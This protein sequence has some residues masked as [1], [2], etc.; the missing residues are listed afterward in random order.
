M[1]RYV[2]LCIGLV[3]S[4]LGC[5]NDVP[6]ERAGSS[7]QASTVLIQAGEGG[8]LEPPPPPT[9]TIT[10]TFTQ[11]SPTSTAGSSVQFTWTGTPSFDSF[12]TLSLYDTTNNVEVDSRNE[13]G[14]E[15]GAATTITF[16]V[17][18]LG[19]GPHHLEARFSAF[20]LAGSPDVKSLDHLVQASTTTSIY[21]SLP[22]NPEGTTFVYGEPMRAQTMVYDGTPQIGG[23]YPSVPAN[24]TVTFTFGALTLGSCAVVS[25]S[26]DCEI[27]GVPAGSER[28]VLGSFVPS[29]GSYYLGSEGTSNLVTVTPAATTATITGATPEPSV[30]GGPV[31]FTI[32][33]H[34][35]APSTASPTGSVQFFRDGVG[36]PVGSAPLT[37]GP[38]GEST[39]TFTV[40]SGAIIGSVGS[41]SVHVTYV[42]DGPP[43]NFTGSTSSTYAHVVAQDT[44]NRALTVSTPSPWGFGTALTFTATVANQSAGSGAPTGTVYFYDGV[45]LTPT[46][47]LGSDVLHAIGPDQAARITISTLAIG[48]HTITALYGGDANHGVGTV[49]L[50]GSVVKST[51]TVEV[52][53][54]PGSVVYS[55]PVTFGATVH[56]TTTTPTGTVQFYVDGSTPIGSPVSL[57][58]G[59]ASLG[60]SSVAAGTDRPITA[61]YAGDSLYTTATGNGLLTVGLAPTSTALTTSSNPAVAGAPVTFSATV[62]RLGLATAVPVGTVTFTQDGTPLG[63]PQTLDGSG[64]A[65]VTVSTLP[66][67]AALAIKAQYNGTSNFGAS[68][69]TLDQEITADGVTTIVVASPSPSIVG[70]SVTFTATFGGSVASVA[71]GSAELF[72]GATSLGT[73]SLNASGA[74]TFSTST[75]AAGNHTITVKYGGDASHTKSSGTVAHAVNRLGSTTTLATTADVTTPFGVVVP[76]VATVTSSSGV[77]TGPVAFK[78]GDTVLGSVAL[79]ATGKATFNA[80]S[81][82]VGSHALTASFGGD[83]T[84][85]PSASETLSHTVDKATTTIL[86]SSSLNPAP[87]G[88]NVL[89]SA[90]IAGPATSGTPSGTVTFKDGV[91][92][93]GSGSVNASGV[94]QFATSSLGAG[95]HAITAVYAGDAHFEGS[96]SVSFTQTVSASATAIALSSAPNPSALGESVTLSVSVSGAGATPTGTVTFKNGATTLGTATLDAAGKASVSVSALPA[97]ILTLSVQYAGDGSHDPGTA[98]VS[99]VVQK[100]KTTTTLVGSAAS[101]APGVA[102]TFTATVAPSSG[103]ATGPVE[104]FDATTSIG[105]A[106]LSGGTASFSVTTLTEGTHAI[107]ARYNGSDGLDTSISNTLIVT[108]AV[109]A[110]GGADAGADAGGGTTSG[111]VGS[112]S[113][114]S[115]SGSGVADGGGTVGTSSG[116]SLTPGSGSGSGDDC[117]MTPGETGSLTAPVLLGL[118]AVLT[119]RR[120]KVA[121]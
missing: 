45:D 54:N 26:S 121:V 115:S 57:I 119:R 58:S 31:Q 34:S 118:L 88:F 61:V 1:K 116:V 2:W 106:D 103:V 84:H 23:A 11:S 33:V 97:G 50:S 67:G 86:V 93:I 41:K 16:D 81:L 94:A 43:A 83:T 40:S 38:G 59:F 72:D 29:L 62:T 76:L 22:A 99:H 68:A 60:S 14:V 110:G 3:I 15:S 17:Y 64:V 98:T 42:P 102:I 66:V 111:G 32:Q 44:T 37:P 107:T 48:G 28:M 79:D 24:G 10:S 117:A 46:A 104:L 89:F 73:V 25:G 90:T 91:T 20:G 75:L 13:V 51:P 5:V 53:V 114:A 8:T 36:A 65:K 39:A 35:V 12:G 63:A 30:V 100:G 96:T 70:Q 95:P 101:A 56:G 55:Q 82:G 92:T 47:F 49:S 27:T 108:I 18:W 87:V 105:V 78:D 112:S 6:G 19:V 120:R 52:L 69:G 7:K 21:L 71:T 85:A 109:G 80:T 77:A 74:A 9:G 4:M 113:G